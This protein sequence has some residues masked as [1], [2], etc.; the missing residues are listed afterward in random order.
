MAR[1][2]RR[3]PSAVNK[4]AAKPPCTHYWIIKPAHGKESEGKCRKCYEVRKFKNSLGVDD[5]W[6][7]ISKE[8]ESIVKRISLK[9]FSG[10]N[11]DD[12]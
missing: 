6:W 4:E 11:P 8:G 5:S 12:Y 10:E 1:A 3:T 9:A 2:A 7:H